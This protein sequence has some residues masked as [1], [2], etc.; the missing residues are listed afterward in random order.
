MKTY[1]ITNPAR[2]FTFLFLVCMISAFL[3]FML[4]SLYRTDHVFGASDGYE[5]IPVHRGDTVWSIAGPI[6]SASDRD[7]RDVV[8]TIY[9]MNDLKEKTIYPGDLLKVPV[10]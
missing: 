3:F 9:R 5:L 7:I 2:F 8:R 10:Q 4:F 1:R 6:A